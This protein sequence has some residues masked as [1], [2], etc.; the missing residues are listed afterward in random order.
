VD[1]NPDGY[2]RALADSRLKGVAEY[3]KGDDLAT[4]PTAVLISIRN[5]A[6]V[7]FTPEGELDTGVN[8]RLTLADDAELWVI[9]GQHRVFGLKRAIEEAEAQAKDGVDGAEEILTRLRR[10][11]LI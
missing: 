7:T 10:Y 1:K 9:D 6:H 8:G 5:P 4:L 11:P 3:L 2:Q